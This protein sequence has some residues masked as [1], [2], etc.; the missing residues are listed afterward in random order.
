MEHQYR[1]IAAGAGWRDRADQGLVSLNGRD[2]ASFLH[3]LVTADVASLRDG[4]GVPAAYLTPQGRMIDSFEVLRTGD[5]LW[6]LGDAGGAAAL[7]T[8]LD[9][10][11]FSEDVRAVDVS[12]AWAQV[13]V[14]GAQAAAVAAQALGAEP[15]RVEALGELDVLE[16]GLALIVRR[17]DSTL[18]TFRIVC[19]AAEQA[20]VQEALRSAQAIEF[21]ESLAT[22]LRIEAGRAA[23]HVDMSEDT[24]PLEAGL[25]DRAISTTKGCYVGQEVI[26][27]ILHRG[28]GRVAKRLVVLALPPQV[29]AIPAA[30]TPLSVGAEAVGRITSAVFSP[31]RER[32]VALG[33]VH[34]DH[35]EIG[36]RIV[37]GD[38]GPEAEIMAFAR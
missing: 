35:A 25:L 9:T 17:G 32:V 20:S 6:L 21:D 34:R 24:I 1:I 29:T 22:A 36:R 31:V 13:D 4:R 28:G 12:K 14:T 15:P 26:I 5:E 18:P 33:Y 23:W 10:L 27:R 7:A 2:A 3:A 38:S 30:G 16:V 37:V 8:R 19:P 11:I